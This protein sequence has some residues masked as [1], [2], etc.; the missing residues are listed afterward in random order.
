MAKIIIFTGSGISAESGI[1]TFRDSGGTWENH[2]VYDVCVAGCLEKDRE[3]VL[4]FYDDMRS[5]LE[6]IRPNKAHN[7]ISSLAKKYPDDIKIITQNV[8]DLFERA[9]CEDVMH[10]HGN[11]L[12]LKCENKTCDH[13]IKI[14][15]K[16]QDRNELCT[17]CNSTLRP[18]IIFFNEEAPMYIPLENDLKYCELLIAIGTSGT[19]I[20]VDE[21]KK[22]IKYSI[23]NNLEPSQNIERKKWSKCYYKPATE[24][25]DLIVNDIELY[26]LTGEIKSEK[27]LRKR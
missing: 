5:K 11:I 22:G 25:I 9:G 12:Y 3:L 26:M 7:V 23:L 20:S 10:L 17:Y 14:D 13:S 24:A 2:N 27:T 15:Y 19:V 4:N 6:S 16:A 21:V 8:D 18:D 1:S